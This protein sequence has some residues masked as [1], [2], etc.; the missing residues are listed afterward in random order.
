M[1]IS[2]KKIIV[3][4]LCVA[5]CVPALAFAETKSSETAS[6][7][8]EQERVA[9]PGTVDEVE[10]P[11]REP[12][13]D[14]ASLDEPVFEG[15]NVEGE[16][17][18]TLP[19]TVK[20]AKAKASSK[21]KK[22]EAYEV[23][24]PRIAAIPAIST[25]ENVRSGILLH[26]KAFKNEYDFVKIYRRT[27]DT[28]WEQVK[29]VSDVNRLYWLDT[30]ERENGKVYSYYLA[31]CREKTV[32]GE[33]E[34]EAKQAAK[35]AKAADLEKFAEKI[36]ANKRNILSLA[37]PKSVS[38]KK[39]KPKRWLCEW[40]VSENVSGY[41]VQF[42]SNGLFL[43]W[44]TRIIKNPV[45]GSRQLTTSSKH[46]VYYGRVRSYKV[47]N[48]K[49]IYSAWTYSGNVFQNKKLKVKYYRQKGN[50]R[51]F[52]KTAGQYTGG[53]CISQGACG[54]GKYTYLLLYNRSNGY[55]RIVKVL[56]KNGKVK[57]VSGPLAL[58]HGND[59]TYNSK[60]KFLAVVN[61]TGKPWRLTLVDPKTLE[62]IRHVTVK[63]PKSTYNA[64][65]ETVSGWSGIT[66]IAYNRKRDVYVAALRDSNN[67]VILDSD[68]TI[69]KQISVVKSDKYMRQGLEVTNEFILRTRSPIYA[70]QK[71]NIIS[72][73]DWF[74]NYV[75]QLQTGWIGEAEGAFV[76]GK[77][78]YGNLYRSRYKKVKVK[79][80]KKK[81]YIS[82]YRQENYLYRL[83][84]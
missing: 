72:V 43:T 38:M 11:E 59:M 24:V 44:S 65:E 30:S 21:P 64:T 47:I 77:K 82:V 3:L 53:Y 2:M 66:G 1:V 18:E 55:S 62:I 42:S 6:P 17:V 54:Y 56:T 69:E 27:A 29:K 81:K 22:D 70:S 57:K 31:A 45:K 67:Y 50:R 61:Y 23:T 41:E 33:T 71:Y 28:E 5:L 4:I 8:T 46:P 10:L 7:Q 14:P 80:G 60:E 48:G 13:A 84:F 75:C 16:P 74:G 32:T 12:A 35:D 40:A 20:K 26:W 78:L 79:D 15:E 58:N 36:K 25:I 37:R 49:K 68:F 63:C 19:D 76:Q 83:K 51:N 34:E 52:T 9:E 39:L 73:Y